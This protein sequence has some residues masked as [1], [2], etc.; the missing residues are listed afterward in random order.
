MTDP[1]YDRCNNIGS[2]LSMSCIDNTDD[3]ET[4]PIFL[5]VD[6]SDI[7]NV[8]SVHIKSVI[9]TVQNKHWHLPPSFVYTSQYTNV[10]L[11]LKF[12]YNYFSE[13]MHNRV[14]SF[15][16]MGYSIWFYLN[17]KLQFRISYEHVIEQVYVLF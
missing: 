15:T 7:S 2:N 16:D 13:R 17:L 4:P 11:Y 3:N 12:Q 14:M 9:F 10:Y 8:C 6:T 1:T 5:V